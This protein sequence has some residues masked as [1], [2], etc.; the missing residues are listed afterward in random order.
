MGEI[1]ASSPPSFFSFPRLFVL[2]SFAFS[3]KSMVFGNS[4]NLGMITRK[5]SKFKK[6]LLRKRAGYRYWICS[7]RHLG[8][9]F[10][11]VSGT[12]CM[13][14]LVGVRGSIQYHSEFVPWSPNSQPLGHSERQTREGPSEVC[15]LS[16]GMIFPKFKDCL[17]GLFCFVYEKCQCIF[18][19]WF[20]KILF[21]I[22]MLVVLYFP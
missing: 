6:V 5:M 21:Q 18:T 3:N 1:L 9:E 8:W 10:T 13:T 11:R 14:L 4:Y 15:Y 22:L 20:L 7:W 19:P 17:C 12:R 16:Q 2:S